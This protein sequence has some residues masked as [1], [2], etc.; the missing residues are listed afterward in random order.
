M[1]AHLHPPNHST[2]HT[3]STQDKKRKLPAVFSPEVHQLVLDVLAEFFD[4]DLVNKVR[5]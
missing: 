3:N 2:V 1:R 5:I 4:H